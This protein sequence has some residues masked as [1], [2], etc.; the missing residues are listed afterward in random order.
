MNNVQL[1]LTALIL[2]ILFGLINLMINYISRRDGEPHVPFRKKLWLIPLLSAFII[3]PLELFAM[4]YAGWFPLP[5]PAGSGDTLAFDS[6]G[7]LLGFSLIV[8]IGFLI[9]ES[10]IHPLVI[11]L[12]RLLLRKDASIYIKQAVTIAFDTVLLYIVS[13]LIPAIPIGGWLQSLFIA[14]FFHLIEWILIGVQAWVQQR[15]RARA[16]SA[17]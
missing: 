1:I 17:G 7:V 10:L 5:D 4:L 11:A 6:N 9:F 13:L 15:K 14:L 16:E 2:L 12:L 3:I 8:L